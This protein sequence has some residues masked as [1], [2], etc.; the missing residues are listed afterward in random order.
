MII[1]CEKIRS[2]NV[3]QLQGIIPL[4]SDFL[5]HIN[6]I[7]NRYVEFDIELLN[8]RTNWKNWKIFW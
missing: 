3:S 7:T 8:K 1:L 5:G 2:L 6:N 4:L